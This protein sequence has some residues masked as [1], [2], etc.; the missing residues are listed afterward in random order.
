MRQLET[1]CDIRFFQQPHYRGSGQLAQSK[2][3]NAGFVGDGSVTGESW[4]QANAGG[5]GIA[6]LHNRVGARESARRSIPTFAKEGPC[7][8]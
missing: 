8:D 3:A 5:C 4:G 2:I 7:N 1:G 6:M